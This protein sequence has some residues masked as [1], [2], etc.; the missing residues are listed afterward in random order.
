[1][2]KKGKS[3]GAGS[4]DGKVAPANLV[5]SRRDLARRL[6]FWHE[7][8]SS[9]TLSANL[10]KVSK[11]DVLAEVQGD[12]RDY[13]LATLGLESLEVRAERGGSEW[14]DG[15]L[16][17][18]AL[19]IIVPA[20]QGKDDTAHEALTL[21]ARVETAAA[22]VFAAAGMQD[23]NVCF[24]SRLKDSVFV[25]GQTSKALGRQKIDFATFNEHVSFFCA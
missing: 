12:P 5:F 20:A 19:K 13:E 21:A 10:L 2:G 3:P 18:N 25:S 4:G 1:M 6:E 11:E 14:V 23:L 8:R 15:R 24:L 7:I 22:A 16:P 9:E 17:D